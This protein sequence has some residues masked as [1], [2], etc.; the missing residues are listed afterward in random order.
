MSEHKFKLIHNFEEILAR[1]YF[2]ESAHIS[3][4]DDG[5]RL[6]D[7]LG[8]Y[9]FKEKVKCGIAQCGTKHQKGYVVKLT[10]GTEII[11]GHVCGKRKFGVDFTDKER[12]FKAQRIHADQFQTMKDTFE[13]LSELK[14]K[15]EDVMTQ[16]GKLTF[17][18]IKMGIKSLQSEAFD[19]WMN[20]KIKRQVTANGAITEERFK[21]DQERE[22]EEEVKQGYG[23]GTSV[24]DTKVVT[25]ALIDDY[26]LISQWYEAD[27][28]RN[29]FERMHREIR[30]PAGMPN[31]VFKK[32]IRDLKEYDHNLTLLKSFCVRG[33]RLLIQENILKFGYLFN[34]PDE[35]RKVQ[36]FAEKYS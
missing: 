20:Q 3:S 28:L 34:K 30:D 21:T 6:E 7:L 8:H 9:Q 12:E 15:F 26:D 22:L 25:V 2:V 13:K 35:L 23:R 33:N 17:I 31:D 11:I 32:L 10:N 18:D 16:T 19:Y 29:Y 24:S 4:G 36:Q 27:K 1:P 5:I 14:Q